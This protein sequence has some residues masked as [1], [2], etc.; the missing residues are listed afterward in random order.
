MERED[1]DKETIE[2]PTAMLQ[3]YRCMKA[4]DGG[5]KSLD[6]GGEREDGHA[7]LVASKLFEHTHCYRADTPKL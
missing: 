1:T 7:N 5:Q 2:I 3:C 4:I 6:P